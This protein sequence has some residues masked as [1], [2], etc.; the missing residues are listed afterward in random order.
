MSS[1]PFAQCIPASKPHKSLYFTYQNWYRPFTHLVNPFVTIWCYSFLVIYQW[2]TWVYMTYGCLFGSSFFMIFTI[3]CVYLPS[4]IPT[5]APKY[6]TIINFVVH[7]VGRSLICTVHP[8][9]K[10]GLYGSK[11]TLFTIVYEELYV[12]LIYGKGQ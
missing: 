6:M 3:I 7:K 11:F 2:P 5:L 1:Q 9:I 10:C 12:M 8:L 4:G